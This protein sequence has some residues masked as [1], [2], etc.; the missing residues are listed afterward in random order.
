YGPLFGK[1][2]MAMTGMTEADVE[3]AKK[4]PMRMYQNFAIMFVGAL[5]MAYVLQHGLLFGNAYLDMGGVT[6]GLTGAFW[7]WFG[8]VAPVTL[9][10]V[11]WEKKPWMYWAINGGYYLVLML[12][13]GVILSLWP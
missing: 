10:P 1:Q 9:A 2:W 12:I 7:F 4:D 5:V 11:L 3:A 13:M 8:L 6:A